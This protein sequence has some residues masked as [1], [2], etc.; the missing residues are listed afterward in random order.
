VLQGRER[1]VGLAGTVEE[2]REEIAV[3][4]SIAIA[5]FV[6]T[7]SC[8]RVVMSRYIDRV[9]VSCSQLQETVGAEAVARCDN[10]SGQEEEAAE[11]EQAKQAE[12]AGSRQVEQAEQAEQAK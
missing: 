2:Y 7:A 11:T 9:A 3:D 6:S 4:R 12:R 5:Q 8:R 1:A 10:C